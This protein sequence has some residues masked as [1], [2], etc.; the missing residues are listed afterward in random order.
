MSLQSERGN[1]EE[2]Q[3]QLAAVAKEEQKF[4]LSVGNACGQFAKENE[5][6]KRKLMKQSNCLDIPDS[7]R[8]K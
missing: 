8:D 4:A 2:V 7:F 5:L 6:A 1:P 3:R